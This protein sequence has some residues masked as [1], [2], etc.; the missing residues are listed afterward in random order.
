MGDS[1]E[2][3]EKNKQDALFPLH[4]EHDKGEVPGPRFWSTRSVLVCA[5]TA[6]ESCGAGRGEEGGDNEDSSERN[7]LNTAQYPSFTLQEQ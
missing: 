6:H 4:L 7:T 5:H 2:C 3:D 1:S